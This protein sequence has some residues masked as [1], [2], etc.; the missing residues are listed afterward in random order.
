[1]SLSVVV[2]VSVGRHPVSNR[3]LRSSQDARAVEL[4]LRLPSAAVRLLHA[5][6]PNEVA[7][8]DYLGM[9]VA[10]LDIV[11]VASGC[12]PRPT[13]VAEL[14]KGIP[15]LL[16][17][18][19]RGDTGFASGFLPYF[20]AAALDL[21]LLSHVC[22]IESDGHVHRVTCAVARGHRRRYQVVGPAVL[23]VGDAAPAARQS[24]FLKARSGRI[25]IL[26]G[27]TD[28]PVFQGWEA[29][30]SRP[31]PRRLRRFKSNATAEERLSAVME[32]SVR[33]GTLLQRLSAEAAAG[34]LL[35]W[36]QSAGFDPMRSGR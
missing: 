36:L 35:D 22:A 5:G 13:L 14:I 12:D 24:A 11:P 6:D 1:M 32:H 21:P 27:H 30:A 2:L 29:S 10:A 8:R 3:A 18:G 26:S 25:N 17:C 23:T 9:G 19:A 15:A 4:A 34:E 16:L 20:L 28:A 7:L 33:N 31:H